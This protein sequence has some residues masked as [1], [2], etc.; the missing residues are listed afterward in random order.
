MKLSDN[1]RSNQRKNA[2]TYRQDTDNDFAINKITMDR[3]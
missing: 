2:K 3:I 1:K